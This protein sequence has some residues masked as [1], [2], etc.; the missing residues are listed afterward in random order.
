MCLKQRRWPNLVHFSKER[1]LN[2]KAPRATGKEKWLQLKTVSCRKFSEVLEIELLN[3]GYLLNNCIKLMK[4]V[5]FAL[6]AF[7]ILSK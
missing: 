5:F 7:Q 3:T 4:W 2:L 1:C 6:I